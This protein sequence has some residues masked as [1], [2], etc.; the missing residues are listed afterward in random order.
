MV[1]AAGDGKK[2]ADLAA[3]IR[4][5]SHP[6]PEGRALRELLAMIAEKVFK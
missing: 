4:D 5:N 6:C 3:W 2:G 1:K